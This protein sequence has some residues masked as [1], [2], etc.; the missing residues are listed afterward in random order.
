MFRGTLE[1]LTSAP[2]E[3]DEQEVQ[4]RYEAL[5]RAAGTQTEVKLTH[6]GFKV[7]EKE[8]EEE[9][10]EEEEFDAGGFWAWSTVV[11][12]SVIFS[13]KRG[14][15]DLRGRIQLPPTGVRLW[16]L[17]GIWG[18][19]RSVLAVSFSSVVQNAQFSRL[20]HSHLHAPFV[21]NRHLVS[22]PFPLVRARVQQSLIL[23]VGSGAS[24][25]S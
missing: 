8:E 23:S 15:A 6:G 2:R 13:T 7:E 12:A 19:S 25:H 22:P 18:I 14:M 24:R 10:E 20:L 9:E 3:L 5:A 16:V 17:H 1:E 4:R 21:V 11:G